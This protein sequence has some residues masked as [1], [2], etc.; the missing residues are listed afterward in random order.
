MDVM[1]SRAGQREQEIRDLKR[2]LS[3]LVRLIQK[4]NGDLEALT[5][6]VWITQ[7]HTHRSQASAY[8]HSSSIQLASD[9]DFFTL[10]F[11]CRR[12]P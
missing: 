4:L 10:S 11:L 7:I 2:D 1:V 8:T 5:R 12:S 3:D 6:K 9:L